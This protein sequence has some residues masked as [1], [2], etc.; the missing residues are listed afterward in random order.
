MSYGNCPHAFSTDPKAYLLFML[1]RYS[2]AD[3]ILGHGIRYFEQP[4]LSDVRLAVSIGMHRTSNVSR[5]DD[6]M[7]NFIEIQQRKRTFWGLYFLDTFLSLL[8][9]RP[10]VIRGSDVDVELP[11]L[12]PD[13]KIGG[14]GL[15]QDD[16][17]EQPEYF[18][19]EP[20]R[21]L[22]DVVRKIST[23][24][25]GT[26]ISKD[27]HL[28]DLSSSIGLLGGDLATWRGSLPR[29]H[30]PFRTGESPDSFAGALPIRLYFSVAYYF[31]QCLVYRPLLVEA[32]HRSVGGHEEGSQRG[33]PTGRGQ[34]KG[35]INPQQPD[36]WSE[37]M[38]SLAG[39]S[40]MAAR[41][42]LNLVHRGGFSM[43]N[44]HSYIAHPK[45]SILI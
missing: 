39:R 44:Q 34:T 1:G 43:I 11:E 36:P 35:Y 9:G 27:R 5:Q 13:S 8:L 17:D 30:L 38:E 23:E 10:P 42:L 4:K 45:K 3:N 25:Y 22:C 21:T 18:V 6:V 15:L 37:D 16:M 19:Y 33:Q 41:D 20:L 2:M 14:E 12:K 29:E 26:Q 31:C 40:A 28:T 24:L 7:L 32:T